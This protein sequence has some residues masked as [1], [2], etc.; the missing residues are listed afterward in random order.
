[1]SFWCNSM[2]FSKLGFRF[3]IT[4]LLLVE[5]HTN[6]QIMNTNNITSNIKTNCVIIFY[7]PKQNRRFVNH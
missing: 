6:K 1:L 2:Y 7:A 5:I 3:L 4:S